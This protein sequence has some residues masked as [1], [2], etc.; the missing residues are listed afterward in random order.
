[1]DKKIVLASDVHQGGNPFDR[2]YDMADRDEDAR[3]DAVEAVSAKAERVAASATQATGRADDSTLL[4]ALE[5]EAA[6]QRQAR[7]LPNAA[8][9]EHRAFYQT[10]AL[11][12]PAVA[13]EASPNSDAASRGAM[14]PNAGAMRLAA[15]DV[16]PAVTAAT[17]DASQPNEQVSPDLA[18]PDVGHTQQQAANAQSPLPQPPAATTIAIKRTGGEPFS[19]IVTAPVADGAPAAAASPRADAKIVENN[20][21]VDAVMVSPSIPRLTVLALGEPD[22]RALARFVEKP[23]QTVRMSFSNDPN[24]GLAADHFS[25]SAVVFMSTLTYQQERQN[26]ALH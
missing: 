10:A 22:F 17:V 23:A 19:K 21:W 20:P 3:E 24:P 26:L 4:A 15:S 12:E 9:S 14:A 11:F 13:A 18:L 16:F 25:G 6:R 5:R 7:L 8:P 2:Y 1:V